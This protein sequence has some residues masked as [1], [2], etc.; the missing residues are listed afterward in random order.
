MTTGDGATDIQILDAL[1]N[2]A[3]P[4]PSPGPVNADAL[5]ADLTAVEDLIDRAD[6]VRSTVYNL[7]L[8]GVD[9]ATVGRVRDRLTGPDT[10][11]RLITKG[12]F[13]KEHQ[14]GARERVRLEQER[15][16]LEKQDRDEERALRRGEMAWATGLGLPDGFTVPASYD[17]SHDGVLFVPAEGT[18]QRAA[19]APLVPLRILVDP[20]GAQ[21][22]ELAWRT[23]GRWIRRTVPK[24]TMKSGRRMVQALGDAGLPVIEADAKAAE[25]WLAAVEAANEEVIPREPLARWLGWQ[26]DGSFLPAADSPLPLE[27]KYPEQVPYI[28]AHHPAGSLEDWRRTIKLIEPFPAVRVVLAAGFAAAMLRV[29]RLDSF[30]LDVAGT[31]SRGKTT[32]ARVGLSPWADPGEKSDGMHSWRTKLLAAEFRLNAVRGMPVPFDESQLVEDPSIVDTILYSVPRNHGQHRGGGWPS[33]LPWETIIISTGERPALSFT[34]SQ[35]AAARVLSL[36]AAPMGDNSP[37]NGRL[38]QEIVAGVTSNYGTAGPAFVERLRAELAADDAADRICA[39]HQELAEQLA[40]TTGMSGRRAPMVAALALADRCICGW[41]I[42]PLEP[43]P[44][45][46]WRDLLVTDDAEDNRGEMALDLV[47]E[48]VAAHPVGLWRPGVMYSE[49]NGGWIGR[50]LTVGDQDAVGLLPARLRAELDRHGVVL[51]AVVPAWRDAGHL[52][53][54]ASYRPPYLPKKKIA[55]SAVRLYI[56]RPSVLAAPSLDSKE[57]DDE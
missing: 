43:L 2:S 11:T 30:V 4:L 9:F 45:D 48:I 7:G 22:V 1:N 49:P 15:A 14:R 40:G 31:S 55:G 10:K 52:V 36:R 35:G 44:M 53:E 6:R 12:E 41:G 13:D 42:V 19:Y 20:D 34:S 54:E 26:P 37:E 3:P 23:G 8:T 28:A 24:S 16:D 57:G 21:G 56:F 17:V 47:R 50:V 33:G 25:R 29:L 32:A 5:A 27:P 38:A 39:R 51:D 46:T 18:P